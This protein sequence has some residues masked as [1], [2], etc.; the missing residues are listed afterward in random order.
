MIDFLLTGNKSFKDR[1]GLIGFLKGGIMYR[2]MHFDRDTMNSPRKFNA[3][4]QAGILYP[5]EN[6]VYWSLGYQG[7][8]SANIN[9]STT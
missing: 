5:M 6:Q 7:I 1:L 2:S 8:L 3:E 9:L 4:A